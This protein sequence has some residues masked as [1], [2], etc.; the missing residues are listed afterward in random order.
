MKKINPGEQFN[1]SGHIFTYSLNQDN[2]ITFKKVKVIKNKPD[3]IPPNIDEV[4]VFFKS[5][6]YTQDSANKFHEYYSAGEWK[7]GGGKPVKNWKQKA[8]SVWFKAENKEPIK[9]ESKPIK[10]LF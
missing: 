1:L 9:T 5:K 6:G 7:D 2:S 10:F 4:V 8:I 3:F